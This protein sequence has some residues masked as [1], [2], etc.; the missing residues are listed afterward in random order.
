MLSRVLGILSRALRRAAGS[1]Q[2][3]GGTAPTGNENTL[4]S[5]RLADAA[6]A[7][8]RKGARSEAERLCKEALALDAA[9]ARALTLSGSIALDRGEIELACATF[10]DILSR[11]PHHPDRAD[12]LANAAEGKRRAGDWAA[13][14]TLAGQALAR[15]P[16]HRGACQVSAY[17]LDSLGDGRQAYDFFR[18][19]LQ[20]DPDDI[21]LHSGLLSLLQRCP[22][23][24]ARGVVQ[25]HR[26]WGVRH[27]DPLSRDAAP[28][29]N[30]REP[31]RRLRVGYVSADLVWHAVGEFIDPVLRA[32]DRDRFEVHFYSNGTRSD[33]LT[34]KLQQAADGWHGIADMSDA[35]AAAAIRMDGI[36]LLVDLSGHTQGNRL[37]LFAHKPAPVQFT[38]LGYLGTTGLRA[39]DYRISDIHS[40]P[41]GACDDFYTERLLLLPYAQWCYQPPP[42]AREPGPA[43]SGERGYPVFGSFNNFMKVSPELAETW[44]AILERVPAARLHIAGVPQAES[45]DWLLDAFEQRGIALDRIELLP[46]LPFARY[47]EEIRAVDIALDSFPQAGAT[48]TCDTLWMGAPTVCLAGGCGAGRAGASILRTLD[49]DELVAASPQAYADIAACLAGNAA[50]TQEY[51]RSLRGRMTAAPFMQPERFTRD[52]EALYRRAWREYCRAPA[53]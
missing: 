18:R 32:H 52:L 44:C 22:I 47:L 15:S 14:L 43:P 24:D 19:I 27:A 34:A 38:Y 40:D 23:L 36:D 17:A 53:A 48:T 8:Y 7:G 2:G 26:A 37:L 50:R 42:G 6:L 51:R 25:E 49:L 21:A 33:A 1:R 10:D 5:A 4:A 16:E 41:P 9:N 13:A 11:F 20:A 46:R 31:E 35:D 28:H 45:A 12:H 3:D 39:I 29:A 30:T